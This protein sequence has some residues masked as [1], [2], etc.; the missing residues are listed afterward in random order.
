MAEGADGAK[1]A[2]IPGSA[3]GVRMGHVNVE[4][5]ALV[6][7][8][9][10]FRWPSDEMRSAAGTG[11][12]RAETGAWGRAVA[13]PVSGAAH[14]HLAAEDCTPLAAIVPNA[15]GGDG[16]W[17]VYADFDERGLVAALRLEPLPMAAALESWDEYVRGPLGPEADAG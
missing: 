13:T 7:A 14:V 8:D 5:G 12:A 1:A 9:L 4:S 16:I 17:A 10:A 3:K 11:R 15:L 2:N 6:I